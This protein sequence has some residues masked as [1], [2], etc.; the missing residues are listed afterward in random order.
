MSS[1]TPQDYTKIDEVLVQRL[2]ECEWDKALEEHCRKAIADAEAAGEDMT[3]DKLEKAATSFAF[4]TVPAS[5]H[6]DVE[7]LIRQSMAP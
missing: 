7:R 6:Y 1:L 3:S 2:T 5:V 4:E